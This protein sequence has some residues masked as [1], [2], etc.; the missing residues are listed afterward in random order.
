MK[1]PEIVLSVFK[2]PSCSMNLSAI[3]IG[4]VATTVVSRTCRKCGDRWQVIVEPL[5]HT[6]DARFDKGTLTFLDN[7][8]TRN[9]LN[10]ERRIA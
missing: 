8:A 5:K 6:D 9:R 1:V 2:C 3:E 4:S 10:G 7:R